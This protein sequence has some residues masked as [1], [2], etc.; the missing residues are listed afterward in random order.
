MYLDPTEENGRAF[1]MRQLEG[2]FEMLN[3]L[4]FRDVADYTADPELAPDR[5]ISGRQAYALYKAH[6]LPFL[7][8]IG[9]EVVYLGEGG[10]PLIGPIDEVWHEV[11]LVR[12]PSAGEFLQFARNKAY[13]AGLGHRT[14]ALADS[15]L[16]PLQRP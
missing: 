5:R 3:L 9:A 2:P 15:R 13:L 1:V 12:H 10:A 11:L 4:R 8:E 6:T 7:R 14:A 16:I